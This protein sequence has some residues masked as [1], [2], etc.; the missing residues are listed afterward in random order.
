MVGVFQVLQVL[1]L[2]QAFENE[3]V[4][5]VPA[6]HRVGYPSLASLVS[7]EFQFFGLVHSGS[8]TV[9]HYVMLTQIA[10][11]V[12]KPLGAFPSVV[13]REVA[14]PLAIVTE[15]HSMVNRGHPQ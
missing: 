13:L 6:N 5:L 9:S 1:L 4:F 3:Q 11:S 14:V 12:K 10:R 15:E 2:L 7:S 8:I